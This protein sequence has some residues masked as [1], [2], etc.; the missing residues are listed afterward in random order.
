MKDATAPPEGS[1]HFATITI[2]LYRTPEG[3]CCY[4]QNSTVRGQFPDSGNANV[5]N[6]LAEA[7]QHFSTRPKTTP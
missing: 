4:V 5:C 6:A 1:E 3:D 2:D 7:A